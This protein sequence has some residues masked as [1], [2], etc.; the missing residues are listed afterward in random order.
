MTGGRSAS[1]ETIANARECFTKPF[2]A[3]VGMRAAVILLVVSAGLLAAGCGRTETPAP[4]SGPYGGDI[5]PLKSGAA[6][7]EFVANPDT[8]EV[9]VHTW[10]KDLKTPRPVE[11]EP[12]TVGTGT[13]SADLMPH[14]TTTDPLGT[15]SRFYGHAEWARGGSITHGW[16]ISPGDR[17]K[18]AFDWRQCWQGGRAHGRMWEEM[19]E[20]RRM[21]PGH[22]G[23]MGAGHHGAGKG[24]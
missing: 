23:P 22:G 13:T 7:A 2:N 17:E 24:E 9:M 4:A 8:G 1:T 19:G 12:I 14:P 3:E 5:V 16:M 18:H 10:D 11:K 6:Y 20:H 15:C 21:G